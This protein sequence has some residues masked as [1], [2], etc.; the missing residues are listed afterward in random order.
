[1]SPRVQAYP[2]FRGRDLRKHYNINTI[3]AAESHLLLSCV[4]ILLLQASRL[5]SAVEEKT[6]KKLIRARPIKSDIIYTAAA[7]HLL[8]V[9]AASSVIS[10][11]DGA[12]N[13]ILAF[14][15]PFPVVRVFYNI[16]LDSP[17]GGQLQLQQSPRATFRVVCTLA[18]FFLFFNAA[19]VAK[20]V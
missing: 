16:I 5:A 15:S 14:H 3:R 4:K 8:K 17:A 19:V 18:I 9:A 1:M 11:R 6:K 10:F 12:F 20:T 13:F 2:K 7:G